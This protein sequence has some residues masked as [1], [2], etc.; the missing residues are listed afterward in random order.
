MSK[1][2]GDG[3]G[4]ITEEQQKTSKQEKLPQF[5]EQG[6]LNAEN[7]SFVK[8]SLS[9]SI[10]VD[11]VERPDEGSSD[12]DIE[13]SSSEGEFS[14]Q[15]DVEI[16]NHQ[17]HLAKAR[18]IQKM[19]GV[20]DIRLDN[21]DDSNF[22]EKLIEKNPSSSLNDISVASEGESNYQIPLQEDESGN[23]EDDLMQEF[24]DSPIVMNYQ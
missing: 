11:S 15:D 20:K 12:I 22:I 14:V 18:E 10:S 21:P 23:F 17:L 3:E 16:N 19:L 13:V 7:F 4:I 8:K 24:D 2:I 9:K 6:K 5:E 1:P